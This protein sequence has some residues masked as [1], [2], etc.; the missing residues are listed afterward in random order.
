MLSVYGCSCSGFSDWHVVVM[1]QIAD[2]QEKLFHLTTGFEYLIGGHE[3]FEA[4]YDAT[5]V[6]WGLHGNSM[7]ALANLID[8]NV[9]TTE[10]CIGNC[11][12]V[13]ADHATELVTLWYWY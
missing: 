12:P 10:L 5:S 7:S 3:A 8:V 2:L 11:C 6:R 4:A 9:V 1:L 13:F